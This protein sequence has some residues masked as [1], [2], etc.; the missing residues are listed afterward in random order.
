MSIDLTHKTTLSPGVQHTEPVTFFQE[1]YQTFRQ[2]ERAVGGPV[3]RFYEIG[4]YT[5]CLRFAGSALVPRI[6]PALDHLA[7]EPSEPP[8]LTV[9]L[10]DSA[11]TGTRPPPPPWSAYDYLERGTIRGYNTDRIRTA[12]QAGAGVLNMFDNALRRAIYW[13]RDAS[14][15]PPY[16]TGSPLLTILHWWMSKHGRQYVHAGA[17]GTSTG[18]VL[19][20]GRG[21]SGKST[22][23]LACLKTE[24]LYLGD[25]YCLLDM[26]SPYLAYSLY[27]SGKLDAA[28]LQ[29][30]PHLSPATTNAKRDY[31]GKVLLFVHQ[32]H[33]KRIIK[34]LPVRAIL[35]P[36]ITGQKGTGLTSAS[37]VET[38]RALAPST[39]FQLSGAGHDALQFMVE[40]VKRLP[41]YHLEVGTDLSEVPNVILDLLSEL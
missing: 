28:G 27:N 10:W 2:A 21:G 35:A 23:A 38:L 1:V 5:I 13:L 20:V 3:H 14:E 15:H 4:G 26:T 6:T 25:D 19:L 7:C 29:M 22:T 30:L 17:V 37:E 33:P 32:L 34:C 16:M 40:L 12:F 31:A 41:C 39:I 8:S 9:C 24:L 36:R 18:G 11:S